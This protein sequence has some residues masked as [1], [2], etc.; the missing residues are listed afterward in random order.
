MKLSL[1]EDSYQGPESNNDENSNEDTPMMYGQGG[2][3]TF[4]LKAQIEGQEEAKFVNVR[5]WDVVKIMED[6]LAPEKVDAEE[7][8]A[9]FLSLNFDI[10]NNEE[11]TL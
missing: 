11:I 1:E 6:V 4:R 3:H 2:V 7:I 8:D 9:T 5:R 10:S